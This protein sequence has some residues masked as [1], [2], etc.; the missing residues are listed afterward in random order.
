[1]IFVFDFK[2]FAES[3]IVKAAQFDFA[4]LT[5]PSMAE[6]QHSADCVPQPPA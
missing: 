4:I 5:S 3:F 2:S 1:M 6:A